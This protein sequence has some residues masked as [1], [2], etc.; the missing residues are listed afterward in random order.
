MNTSL[1]FLNL[2]IH[3]FLRSCHTLHMAT[4]SVINVTK[5]LSSM[6]AQLGKPSVRKRQRESLPL[7]KSLLHAARCGEQTMCLVSILKCPPAGHL[8][9]VHQLHNYTCQL[10][11]GLTWRISLTTFDWP[12]GGFLYKSGQSEPFLYNCFQLDQESRTLSNWWKLK[13]WRWM[14][15]LLVTEIPTVWNKKAMCNEKKMKATYTKK[16]KQ[17]IRM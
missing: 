10:L 1:F 7:G 2:K 5:W 9:E 4:T 15:E 13:R 6:G 16:E 12:S 11:L 8:W 14:H 3:D 17:E